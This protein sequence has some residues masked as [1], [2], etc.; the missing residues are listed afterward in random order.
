MT[1]CTKIVTRA[2]NLVGAHSEVNPAD[3]ELFEV[4]FEELVGLIEGLVSDEV[5]FGPLVS[6]TSSGLVATVALTAHGFDVGQ[7]V[8]IAGASQGGYNG[9]ATIATVPTVDSFTYALNAGQDTPATESDSEHGI[10]CTLIPDEAGDDLQEQRGA[11]TALAAILAITMGPLC[12]VP[13]PDDVKMLATKT[14]ERLRA[15]YQGVTIPRLVPSKLL[16]RGAG[17]TRGQQA[18][19]FFGGEDIDADSSS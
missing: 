5:F 19:T 12:R 10:T 11:T 7:T 2:L 4:G 6:I 15:R 18:Q 17:S 14:G 8:V 13:V 9:R 16:P 1:D 3:P